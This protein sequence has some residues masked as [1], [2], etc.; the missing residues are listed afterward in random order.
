MRYH[1]LFL[2]KTLLQSACQ[3]R[4]LPA[5]CQQPGGGSRLPSFSGGSRAGTRRAARS[6]SGRP[7]IHRC[8]W[9]FELLITPGG[10]NT[11]CWLK[12]RL[13]NLN[14]SV[15]PSRSKFGQ[16]WVSRAPFLIP[17]TPSPNAFGCLIVSPCQPQ[18][19]LPLVGWR[20]ASGRSRRPCLQPGAV[21]D[22]RS[23]Q[24]G[25][26]TSVPREP[27]G[28][29]RCRAYGLGGWCGR[30]WTGESSELPKIC[31][32]LSMTGWVA[33]RK[34]VGRMWIAEEEA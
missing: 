30:R 27:P 15:H 34:F 24:K 25:S 4:S 31:G 10:E 19:R 29:R 17:A 11:S 21:P 32:R 20:A 2:C 9:E 26:P 23:K 12:M 18:D 6:R 28:R 16:A 14:L 7:P 3:G 5:I 22:D 33:C 1:T 13:F 8:S